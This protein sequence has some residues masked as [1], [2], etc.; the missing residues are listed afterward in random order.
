MVV[1]HLHFRLRVALVGDFFLLDIAH[2][3]VG[4][5]FGY[6]ECT[7]RHRS[8]EDVIGKETNMWP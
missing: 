2:P 8:Y 1:M 4:P 6:R 5:P 3:V 7:W